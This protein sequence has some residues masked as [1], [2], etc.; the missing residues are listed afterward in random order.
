MWGS[1]REIRGGERTAGPDASALRARWGSGTWE[2]VLYRTGL[3]VAAAVAQQASN[4]RRRSLSLQ[5]LCVEGWP[6]RTSQPCA[7]EEGL[8]DGRMGRESGGSFAPRD[9]RWSVEEREK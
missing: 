4:G 7:G 8:R 5:L 6:F 3:D 1:T 9:R 2:S